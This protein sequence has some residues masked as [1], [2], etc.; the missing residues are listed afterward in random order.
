MV[1]FLALSASSSSE[2]SGMTGLPVEYA[3]PLTRAMPTRTPVKAAGADCDGK[4]VNRCDIKRSVLKQR[5]DMA[6]D[7]CRGCRTG[8]T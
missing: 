5:L 2:E 3:N 6:G 1:L 8:I 4:G 7:F